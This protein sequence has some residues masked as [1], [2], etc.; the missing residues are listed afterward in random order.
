MSTKR[1]QNKA[2]KVVKNKRERFRAYKNTESDKY[3][4]T[5]KEENARAVEQ[6]KKNRKILISIAIKLISTGD[7]TLENVYDV[8][9]ERYPELYKKATVIPHKP[10]TLKKDEDF[11]VKLPGKEYLESR[12]K[13]IKGEQPTVDDVDVDLEEDN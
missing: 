1:D 7:A 10:L 13:A 6:T 3:A 11:I 8:I 2:Y 12:I 9:A 4:R 5:I